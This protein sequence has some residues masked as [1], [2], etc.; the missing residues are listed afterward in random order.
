MSDELKRWLCAFVSFDNARSQN[1]IVAHNIHDAI[2]ATELNPNCKTVIS[3]ALI[4]D[5]G[6][7]VKQRSGWISDT[8]PVKNQLLETLQRLHKR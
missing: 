3:V 4:Q 2:T 1:T 5:S 6:P 7:K 8:L